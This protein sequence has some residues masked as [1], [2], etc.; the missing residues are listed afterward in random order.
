MADL[1]TV[2]Q[3]VTHAYRNG[4]QFFLT[5]ESGEFFLTSQSAMSDEFLLLVEQNKL[6]VY[7][8]IGG[9][10][11]AGSGGSNSPTDVSGLT[12]TLKGLSAILEQRG[13]E[14]LPSDEITQESL[15]RHYYH[16]STKFDAIAAAF[17]RLA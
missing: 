7:A 4:G 14:V 13:L 12:A 10:I 5:R 6:S 3:I 16:F 9:V 1:S 8:A 17:K 15:N 2:S 11:G